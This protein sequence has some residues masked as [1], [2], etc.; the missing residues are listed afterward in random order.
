MRLL[1][2]MF[3]FCLVSLSVA[4][5][6]LAFGIHLTSRSLRQGTVPIPYKCGNASHFIY[7]DG[8]FMILMTFCFYKNIFIKKKIVFF[9]LS[10]D[11]NNSQM[12]FLCIPL[13]CRQDAP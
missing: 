2:K 8:N 6:Y 4:V 7:L 5:A 10:L 12:E 3:V 1:F 11:A 13:E 9:S